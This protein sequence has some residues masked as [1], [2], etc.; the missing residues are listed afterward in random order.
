MDDNEEYQECRGL[1]E[2]QGV[3]YHRGLGGLTQQRRRDRELLDLMF[4]PSARQKQRRVNSRFCGGQN[5]GY[6]VDELLETKTADTDPKLESGG[7]LATPQQKSAA[8]NP[9]KR[10]RRR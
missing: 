6:A 2:G 8:A 9:S 10:S 5:A 3:L 4:H 1:E 7:M